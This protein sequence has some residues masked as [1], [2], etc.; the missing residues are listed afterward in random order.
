MPTEDTT[1]CAIATP[2]GI[3]P[4][5]IVRVSGRDALS[6]S[7]NVFRAPSGRP[8][9]QMRTYFAAEGE[10]VLPAREGHVPASIY[11]MRAPYSYTREDVVEL[12]LPGGTHLLRAALDALIDAGAEQAQPG[13]FTRRAY[14]NGRIDLTQAEAVAA[15]IQS[16]TQAERRLAIEQLRGRFGR[17][18]R[19]IQQGILH[20]LA[21][22]EADLDFS[23]QDIDLIDDEALAGMIA[24]HAKR[25]DEMLAKER[26]APIHRDAVDVTICGRPNVGKS[27]LM[28]GLLG[29]DRSLVSSTSGTTRDLIDD[30]IEI[31]GLHLRLTDTP[32]LA[33]YESPVTSEA[34]ARGR[35]RLLATQIA[36]LVIDR[37]AGL[38]D[39]DVQIHADIQAAAT[40]IAA[41]NKSDL[42]PRI[43]VETVSVRLG[44]EAVAVSCRT[45]AGIP[46]LRETLARAITSAEVD[47]SASLAISNTRHRRALKRCD[48]CLQ[49]ARGTIVAGRERELAAIDLRDAAAELGSIL[50]ESL[51]TP[52]EVLDRVFSQFC[53][54]K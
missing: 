23:D 18:V 44:A 47:L 15:T 2:A 49:C 52:E 4:R 48:T 8:L 20:V 9:A 21:E 30:L 39:E 42:P 25:V 50:G 5:G 14:L 37:S 29:R 41:L 43:A 46:R 1:I 35:E 40:T 27:S 31:D 28:N 32:G 45:G 53:I 16:N 51:D 6:L 38:C 19:Q 54:G 22:I 34:V 24:E 3:G 13:E 33:Q 36:L 12:H 17:Q 11:L 26:A 7:E 10:A